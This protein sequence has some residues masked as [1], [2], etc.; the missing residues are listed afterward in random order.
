MGS[1]VLYI[2]LLQA[3]PPVPLVPLSDSAGPR[4]RIQAGPQKLLV[5]DI[6]FCVKPYWIEKNR[7]L[8]R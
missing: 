4:S 5:N 2:E 3:T 8:T 7:L 6:F 1:S